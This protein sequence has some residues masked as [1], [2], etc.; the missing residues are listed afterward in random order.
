[1][2]ADTDT[3]TDPFEW[4]AI[5]AVQLYNRIRRGDP[6]RILDVRDRELVEQWRITGEQVGHTHVPR[7]KALQA[8]A[9]NTLDTLVADLTGEGPVVVVCSEGEASDEVAGFLREAGYGAVTLADGMAGWADLYVR[10]RLAEVGS[11][12]VSQYRRPS[13]G[14][15]S[16]LVVDRDEAAVIDPLAAFVDRY[17][18][19]AAELGARLAYAVDTHVHADHVS[20]VAQ[21]GSRPETTG[22]LPEGAVERGATIDAETVADGDELT[23]GSATMIALHAPGHTTDMTA[24]RLGDVMLAGDSLFVESV[25]RPDL[26]AGAADAAAFARELHRTLHERFDRLP[27][28]TLVAPGHYSDAAT[29]REDGT[30]AATFGELR[31]SLPL[32]GLDSEDFFERLLEGMGPQPANFERIVE[33]NLGRDAVDDEEALELELGPNNCAAV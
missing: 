2:T 15:L 17:R 5:T 7:V 19:D 27:A 30:Y 4:D 32:Y 23:V 25:A 10:E 8:E 16:Y 9:T 13:S 11:A 31:S 14:C 28:E 18:A 6:V 22:V 21:L 29:P 1:M 26:E 20:G 33:I 24:F 3:D 12:T